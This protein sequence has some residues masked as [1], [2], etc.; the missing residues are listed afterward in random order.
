MDTIKPSELSSALDAWTRREKIDKT[1]DIKTDLDIVVK[2]VYTPL[3]VAGSDYLR[4]QGLPGEYPFTRGNYPQ[5]YRH[6]SWRINMIAAWGGPEETKNRF[7]LLSAGGQAG[8]SIVLDTPT[9]L[10]LDSDDPVAGPEVGRV[11]LAVDTVSD[12]EILFDGLP[13][14][15]MPIA[16]NEETLAG[17]L[18]AMYLVAAR[19]RGIS[20]SELQGTFSNDPLSSAVC[21]RTVVFPLEHACRL[22]LDF[23]EYASQHLPRFR[24]I[25]LKG[26]DLREG[27]ADMAQEMGFL[28][29]NGMYYIDQLVKRGVP[30]D[31]FAPKISFF[32]SNTHH[33]FE[34]AAKYRASRRLWAR[35][36][37][38]R[39]GARKPSS[40]F[41]RLTAMTCPIEFQKEQ[42]R[43][44]MV[45]GAYGALAMA[46]GGCQGMLNPAYDEV[47]DIPSEEGHLLALGTCQVLAEETGVRNTVD[48]LGGSYYVESL[49]NQIEKA[50]VQKMEEVEKQGGPIKAL[51]NGWEQAEIYK[52]MRKYLDDVES[53]KIV[54]VG[55]NKYVTV[56]GDNKVEY[57]LHHPDPEGPRRQIARLKKIKATRDNGKVQESLRKLG[58]AAKGNENLMPYLV[59]AAE[60]HA[61]LGEMVQTLKSVWGSYKE[62]YVPL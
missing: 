57:G 12:F 22:S 5:A 34:E 54:Y 48:P 4:D 51:E 41:L 13:M 38:E 52:S 50:I 42:A 61:T 19:K 39:F 33:I 23:I 53:G 17:V 28:F 24:P 46:L 37:K 31:E 59:A 44:N 18:A 60:I 2:P 35:L 27:Y 20:W 36:L 15:S 32:C 62:P 26:V 9:H 45:R 21:K 3:D 1:P 25:Q 8:F 30:V 58:D 16:M 47:F 56:E 49:T 7:K 14:A 40:M 6:Q 43:L 11:G 29:A 55:R 10:G